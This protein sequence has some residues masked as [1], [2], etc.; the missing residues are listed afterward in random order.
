MSMIEINHLT[1][2]YDGSYDNVFEDLT[3]RL[4][5]SWRLGLVGRNGRGKTTL[6]RLLAGEL[7]GGRA[8]RTGVSARYFPAPVRRPDRMTLEVLG[9][10]CP[11]AEDWEIIRELS[12]LDVEIEAL[13]R[14][15]SSL[16]GGEQTRALLSVLF[17]DEGAFPLIDEP[18]NH[19]DEAG[20]QTV[21]AYLKRQ[22]GFLLVSHDRAFLDGC[23]DHILALEKTG[24]RL[25]AGNY[26]A[27]W[28]DTQRR[29]A[30]EA[31]RDA[32]LKREIGQLRNA[33][34][35]TGDW[36]EKVEKTKNAGA[37]S[38]GLKAD[39]G[40]VGH[41]A[42]KMMRRSKA[43][44]ARRLSAAEEKENLLRN[45]EEAE[46]LKLRPLTFQGPRLLELREAAPV[47]GGRP[48]CPP[49][50]LALAPG[51]RV[52]L[53]GPNGC[54]K[55]SL[56]KL[57]LVEE[58]DH[59]GEVLRPARL[60]VSYL[61]Q[62]TSFLRGSLEEAM[63]TWEVD[64]VLCRA[65]L[66]KLGL[67]RRQFEKDLSGYSAGQKKKV[68]LARSLCQSAHLYVWDEPLNY[69]DLWSRQQVEELILEYRPTLIFVEHD[70]AFREKVATRT[71][72]LG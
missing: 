70:R 52:A 33:A 12:L 7:S 56:L 59:T 62:D 68:L 13:Y 8:V 22:R 35:R 17:L 69:I 16:S 23:V 38:S 25:Q 60:T 48:V 42:A 61:P 49:V 29:T 11:A 43:I 19:L 20:R 10:L 30:W 32:Q 4:D 24:V 15:F 6:L 26:S 57:L 5:T 63:E 51:E 37:A 44:E 54:G 2:A 31:Q 1:F 14:P 34:R 58:L 36:S 18:T 65:I 50:S 45:V 28:A 46:P 40:R 55:T 39:K 47:Y 27:W 64:P 3:L 9:E 67:E 41:M 21:A 71:V 53:T 66:R 72:E